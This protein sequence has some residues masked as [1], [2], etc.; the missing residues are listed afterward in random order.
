MGYQEYAI[1]IWMSSDFKCCLR[2]LLNMEL[3]RTL[4]DVC[5][6]QTNQ[7][8]ELGTIIYI[9]ETWVTEKHKNARYHCK[10]IIPTRRVATGFHT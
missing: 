9:H 3:M 4:K 7:N 6:T 8:H 2:T 10:S 5:A 1:Y